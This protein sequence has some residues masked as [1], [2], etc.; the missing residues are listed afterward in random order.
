M[1][2]A[3]KVKVG[4]GEL[5]VIGDDDAK[6]KDNEQGAAPI[7][8]DDERALGTKEPKAH[9]FQGFGGAKGLGQMKGFGGDKQPAGEK[10]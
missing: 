7:R 2:V 5:K 3:R 8:R 9:R 1:P 4:G 10:Q 6:G